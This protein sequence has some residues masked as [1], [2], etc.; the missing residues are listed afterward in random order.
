MMI[1]ANKFFRIKS[2]AMIHENDNRKT[3][4]NPEGSLFIYSDSRDL[5]LRLL[6]FFAENGRNVCESDDASRP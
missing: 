3:R 2:V 6:R 5:K 4:N 1:I